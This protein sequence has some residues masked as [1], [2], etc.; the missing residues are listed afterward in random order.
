MLEIERLLRENSMNQLRLLK[1]LRVIL[2][3]EVGLSLTLLV[4]MLK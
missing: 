2:L 4:L 3:A 1:I